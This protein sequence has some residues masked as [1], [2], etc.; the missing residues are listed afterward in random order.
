LT[1]AEIAE[2]RYLILQAG[3]MRLATVVKVS[4]YGK[5]SFADQAQAKQGIRHQRM[6]SYKCVH[7]GQWHV[8][9]VR[10]KA[11]RGRDQAR[12]RRELRTE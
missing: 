8:G 6:E 7:C 3:G 5:Q 12:L 11:A 9:T 1:P 10:P 2:L 4:C